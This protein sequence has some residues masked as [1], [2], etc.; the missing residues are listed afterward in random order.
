MKQQFSKSL[1]AEEAPEL[2]VQTDLVCPKTVGERVLIVVAIARVGIVGTGKVITRSI[3]CKPVIQALTPQAPVAVE[4]V[5][6]PKAA[7]P[8]PAPVFASSVP[9]H[10][11]FVFIGVH[12]S[13]RS[14][15][16]KADSWF[17]S[18]SFLVRV[19]SRDSR[20]VRNLAKPENECRE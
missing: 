12:L 2:I 7:D 20:A 8:A 11:E 15:G 18:A 10:S 4:R 5:L 3:L 9:F 13:R 16:A 1:V 19:N 17:G 6:E 14:I